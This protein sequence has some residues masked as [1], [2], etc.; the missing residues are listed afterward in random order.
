MDEHE[1]PLTQARQ[2][3][4]AQAWSTAAAHFGMV[5]AERLT[6]DDH[7]GLGAPMTRCA[8]ALSRSTPFGLTPSQQKP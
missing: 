7:G 2:A 5:P 6:A 1:D 3:H 8:W 4:A